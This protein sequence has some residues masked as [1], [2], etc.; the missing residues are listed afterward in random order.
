MLRSTHVRPFIREEEGR[1]EVEF[2]RDMD[3][4]VVAFLDRL[5]RL[6]RR[7]EGRPRSTVVE[8]LRRQERRVR[9]TRRLDGISKSLLDRCRFRPPAD[10]ERAQEARAALFRA[11]GADWPPTPGNLR[12]P[13]REAARALEVDEERLDALLYADRPDARLLVRAP[14]VDGARLLGLYNLD[15][16]R[17]V[18]LD[19]TRVVLTARGGWRGIFRAVKLAR[20]MYRVER[21][22]GTRPRGRKTGSSYRVELTGP[23]APYVAR[24]RRY[25]SRFARVVPALT[26]APGWRLEAAV[27]R[28]GRRLRFELDGGAP[29]AGSRG[30]GRA[31]Y[32]SSFERSL[33]SEFS[34]K[35]GRERSGWTLTREATPLVVGEEVTLPDFTLRHDDGREALVEIVG[36]W[37]PEYLERKLARLEAGGP[38]NLVLVVYR[39]LGAGE[40]G[41]SDALERAFPG[42]VIRFVRKPVIAE[43]ME[44]VERVAR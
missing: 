20:L 41:D 19:A 34:E 4:R 13:Y 7:L 25:G 44:A 10:A 3:G 14:R 42:R 26:R 27:E 33:A 29:L 11:R 43:V 8:A 21:V 17:G 12:A 23:A 9:D 22:A 32:D 28:E 30:R 15:L 18:L 6:L 37:T 39:D 16:A 35:L 2:L 36:F 1:V 31:R 5:G 38:E 40:E 24:A